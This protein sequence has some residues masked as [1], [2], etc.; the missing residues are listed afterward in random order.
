MRGMGRSSLVRPLNNDW[1][2][3]FALWAESI[4][5]KEH[6]GTLRYIKHLHGRGVIRAPRYETI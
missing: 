1:S 2:I 6:F 3:L 5:T 4:D